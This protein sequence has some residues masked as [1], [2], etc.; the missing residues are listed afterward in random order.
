MDIKDLV[1]E[2]SQ[3]TNSD[4]PDKIKRLLLSINIR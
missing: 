2:L 4:N 1:S 3:I